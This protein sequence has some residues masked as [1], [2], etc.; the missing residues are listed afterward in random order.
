MPGSYFWRELPR[1]LIPRT[2][3]NKSLSRG[4]RGKCLLHKRE[5]EPLSKDSGLLSAPLG[6]AL[7]KKVYSP[8]RASVL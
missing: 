7:S 2:P 1:I 8:Q 5:P 6:V 4:P 3:V